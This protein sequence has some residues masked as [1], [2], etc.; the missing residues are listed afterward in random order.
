MRRRATARR[1]RTR[2]SATGPTSTATSKS[3]A[4]AALYACAPTGPENMIPACGAMIARESPAAPSGAAARYASTSRVSAPARAGI[5]RACD[6]RRLELPWRCLRC[7]PSPLAGRNSLVIAS[8]DAPE[9]HP[10][11]R[12]ARRASGAA[13]ADTPTNRICSRGSSPASSRTPNRSSGSTRPGSS[14]RRIA[15]AAAPM[16]DDDVAPVAAARRVARRGARCRPRRRSL[17]STTGAWLMERPDR[18]P[19][20]S[21]TPSRPA[22]LGRRDLPSRARPHSRARSA[23]QRVSRRRA[24]RALA[25]AAELDAR[26]DSCR[27]CP[28]LG[29]P[30]AIKDNICTRGIADH[31]GVAHPRGLRAALR[32]DRRRAPRSGRRGHR[33]QDQLR[34]VRDGLVDGELRVRPDAQPVG[35][36]SHARRLERRLRGGGG[37]AASCR[38]RSAPIPAARSASPRRSAASSA[39]SRPTAAC[40]ATACIA[41]ASSLDQ[42]GPFATTVADAALVLERHRRARP[43]RLDAS[44]ARRCPTSRAA[45]D[46]RR[47]RG[48]RIGVPRALFGEGVDADVRRARSTRRSTS[49]TRSRR[50]IVDVAL[51]HSPQAIPVYYM[52]ATAEASSNLARYDG[53]RYG[54]RAPDGRDARRDVRPH[55]RRGVRRRSEAPDHARHV[56][57]Q[58]RLLRRLLPQGA[59]GPHADPPR[60]RRGV[61]RRRR[62]RDAD[63]P[64]AAFALGERTDDPL[65]MYSSDVFTVG[66]NLAGLPASASPAASRAPAAGRPAVHRPPMD[67]ATVLRVADVY[68]RATSWS[69]ERPAVPLSSLSR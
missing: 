6:R 43:A 26:A 55:A 53:V 32:R 38:S 23:A 28:L 48:L 59:A 5:P 27:L 20:T 45:L 21:G 2:R 47:S 57:A 30:V 9:F 34:R 69:S 10:R 64:D 17:Q 63:Q 50:E 22:E 66:A 37:G 60:L 65:Q 58:R 46:R 36:R 54:Y 31:R 68:E 4:A 33:R 19:A 51:P 49:S 24:E 3:P 62:D 16:R 12:R 29:V 18:P 1:P 42:I 14:R 35:A 25:R 44:A 61:R 15:G 7:T 13:R 52:I 67:D 40:R 39:S 11:G 8:A 56:R 41:F